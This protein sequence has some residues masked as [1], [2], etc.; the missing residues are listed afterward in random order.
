LFITAQETIGGALQSANEL[1]VELGERTSMTLYWDPLD[2][3]ANFDH[4][5]VWYG[6]L[7]NTT[8][9][10]GLKWDENSDPAMALCS[11]STTTVT[12]L[13]PDVQYYFK[14]FAIDNDGNAVSL[15]VRDS[16]PG[17]E[18]LTG[19]DLMDALDA[20]IPEGARL[21]DVA[22]KLGDNHSPDPAEDARGSYKH[23]DVVAVVLNGH[24]WTE[25]EK[26]SF[27]ITQMVLT[28][29]EAAGLLK[30]EVTEDGTVTKRRASKIE[31]GALGLTGADAKDDIKRKALRDQ[32]KGKRL[33]KD[34][35][36]K[37]KK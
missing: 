5:E 33:K 29:E 32:L 2:D 19:D 15:D 6:L 3:C 1:T 22:I 9:G 8:L 37:E 30:P 4:Y 7:A 27:L 35:A 12:N 31:M 28:E 24:L 21:Y 20:N 26:A 17:D 16:G 11:T 14:L 25:N 10:I 34:T 13:L 23:G 18:E 36:V